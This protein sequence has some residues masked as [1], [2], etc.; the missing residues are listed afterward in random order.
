MLSHPKR[1]FSRGSTCS[2]RV[3]QPLI[4]IL[5]GRTSPMRA[6]TS[7]TQST[8][9]KSLELSKTLNHILKNGRIDRE[10][11]VSAREVLTADFLT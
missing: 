2:Q 8:P 9:K 3:T 4:R 1:Q 7:K 10:F 6:R 11:C 5:Q